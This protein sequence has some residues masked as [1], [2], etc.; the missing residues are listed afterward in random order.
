MNTR[1][2]HSARA[3]HYAMQPNGY[4]AFIPKPLPPNPPLAINGDLLT[5]LSRAD[6]AIGR[7][8]GIAVAVPDPDFFLAMYVRKEAVLSSQ[9]EGTQTSLLDLLEFEAQGTSRRLPPDV[10]EVVRYV[11]AM[12]YG[13][14]RL[15]SLPLSLR[16]L[17]EIHG[18]LLASG[19]GSERDPGQFRRS[20]NWIGP[21]GCTLTDAVF[22][23]P[24]VPDM[25]DALN[26]LERFIHQDN[27]LP[28]LVKCALIHSHFE[29]VHPF[30]GG[31]GRLGRL[32]ITFYLCQQGILHHPM[33]YL[34]YYLKKNR[35]EYYDRLM[36]VREKGDWEGWVVFFLRG[37][38]EIAEE[39]TDVAKRLVQMRDEHRT[40]VESQIPRTHNAF[41]ILSGLYR[42]P[43]A[44]VGA[45]QAQLG[46]SYASANRLIGRL[47][48]IGILR[49]ITSAERNRVF[50]YAPYLEVFMD[51]PLDEE[52]AATLVK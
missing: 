45:V 48:D 22:V 16:L 5:L 14:E 29:T 17:R 35:Q 40:L 27:A 37:V 2:A 6:R 28:A 47:A 52:T 12:N 4:R 19:R 9:I 34:S 38:A 11:D 42:Q 8:D 26:D 23:P 1:A 10:S 18:R 33:L 46:I 31:N 36:A 30:L 39:A 49:A 24:P 51:D 7:L 13:L 44:T 50:A 25:L 20:Q 15:K 32:L 3:G 21:P 41:R 43:V